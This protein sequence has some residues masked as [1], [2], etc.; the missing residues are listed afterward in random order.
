MKFFRGSQND[1]IFGGKTIQV[2]GEFSFPGTLFRKGAKILTA[3]IENITYVM[4]EITH[5]YIAMIVIRYQQFSDLPEFIIPC[6][7]DLP[8]L[9]QFEIPISFLRTVVIFYLRMQS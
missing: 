9:L 8:D 5:I 7:I 3:I 6:F 4:I 1:M 2:A